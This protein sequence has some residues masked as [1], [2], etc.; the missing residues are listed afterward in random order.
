MDTRG[1]NE[2]SFHQFV[3]E[4]LEQVMPPTGL[5]ARKRYAIYLPSSRRSSISSIIDVLPSSTETAVNPW[6]F[7]AP[8]S[9]ASMYSKSSARTSVCR[10]VASTGTDQG[11]YSLPNSPLAETGSTLSMSPDTFANS[12]SCLVERDIRIRYRQSSHGA[13]LDA[14]NE[15]LE[16]MR[17]D[18]SE[19]EKS[20]SC[21]R[22]GCNDRLRDVRALTY[23]LHIHNMTDTCE[24]CSSS[25]GSH[26]SGCHSGVRACYGPYRFLPVKCIRKA[27]SKLLR[28]RRLQ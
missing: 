1:I 19:G 28:C 17:K 22:P 9:T 15:A 25:D 27:I 7:P 13:L 2:D 3:S 21:L 14:R 5:S 24:S 12:T 18:G 26:D 11:S 4:H 8:E 10:S 23:H 6:D 20:I 16:F